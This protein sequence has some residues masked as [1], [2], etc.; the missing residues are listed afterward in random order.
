MA[1]PLS[2]RT[3]GLLSFVISIETTPAETNPYAQ[4]LVPSA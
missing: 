1:H 4:L 3:L 2:V